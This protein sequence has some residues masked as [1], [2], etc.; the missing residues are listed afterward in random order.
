VGDQLFE[1]DLSKLPSS[2]FY[3]IVLEGP[4]NTVN[5]WVRL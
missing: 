1:I 4:L 2:D 5:R 3:K